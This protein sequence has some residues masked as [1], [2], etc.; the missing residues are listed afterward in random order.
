MGLEICAFLKVITVQLVTRM[1][2]VKLKSVSNLQMLAIKVL[3]TMVLVIY[4]FQ[5]MITV[6]TGTKMMEEGQ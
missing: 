3:K 2:D 1:T 4:A 6:R 5:I